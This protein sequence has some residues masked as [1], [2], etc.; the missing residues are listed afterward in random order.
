MKLR[1]RTISGP[2]FKVDGTFSIYREDTE[3]VT[4]RKLIKRNLTN[5]IPGRPLRL[6][7]I[8]I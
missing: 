5:S 3:N 1:M 7:L 2:S 6:H 8:G 4:K